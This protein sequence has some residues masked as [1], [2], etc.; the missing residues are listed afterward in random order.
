MTVTDVELS[1]R[2]APTIP[3]VASW[4]RRV[5][6]ALLDTAVLGAVAWF[7][8]GGR[9][10]VPSLQPTFDSG[11]E[12]DLLPW[13]SSGAVVGAVV[14]MLALQGLTGQTPGR[15][16]VGIQVVR[17]PADGPAG[18]PPGVL[19]SVV[20]CWAHLLDAILLIGYLRP[21][22]HPEG[23]TF[24]DGLLGTVVVR[25]PPRADGRGR[26]VTVA[27]WLV[28]AMGLGFGVQVGE[29]QGVAP[30]A[31]AECALAPQGPDGPR[32]E[33]VS[34]LRSEEWRQ[35]RTLWPWVPGERRVD[36]EA[37]TIDVAWDAVVVEPEVPLVVR[38]TVDGATVVHEVPAS[39]G[40]ASLPL[41]DVSTSPVDVEVA[42]QERVLTSCTVALPTEG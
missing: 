16:V 17:A 13:T 25:R 36:G 9:I 28:V 21:L 34:A 4:G 33:S 1:T 7:A 12:T 24:A 23:R 39:E 27:A 42:W 6:A 41:D 2:V 26:P 3:G 31:Y 18:G 10:A 40:Q 14:L 8:G 20:R 29:A 30:L 35:T 19:R 38:T 15:R 32:V 22:W 37:V 5:V 11:P